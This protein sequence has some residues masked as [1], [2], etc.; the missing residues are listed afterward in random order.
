[1]LM[2][3]SVEPVKSEE[4]TNFNIQFIVP[5]KSCLLPK[6]PVAK[7]YLFHELAL[8]EVAVLYCVVK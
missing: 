8:L 7:H 5:Y 4:E 2:L 1:M 6:A 3:V